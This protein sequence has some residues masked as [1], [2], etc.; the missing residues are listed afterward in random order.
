MTWF[1]MSFSDDVDEEI[2]DEEQNSNTAS[3]ESGLSDVSSC[4]D[5][6]EADNFST[7]IENVFFL[8]LEE[9]QKRKNLIDFDKENEKMVFI[10]ECRLN[11]L[12]FWM[13]DMNNWLSQLNKDQLDFLRFVLSG[14]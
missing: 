8:R 4:I 3:E 5:K 14:N 9:L 7:R 2:K 6:E 11:F 1:G 13:P 10:Q 12:A